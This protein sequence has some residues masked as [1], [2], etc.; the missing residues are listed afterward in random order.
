MRVRKE[1]ATLPLLKAYYKADPAQF[2]TDWG[3][4]VD[5]R[6]VERGLPALIPFILTPR[7]RQWVAYIIDCWKRQKPGLTEKSRDS[8]VSWLAVSLAC[9]LCLFYD[10]MAVGFGSRKEEYVDKLGAPKALFPKA[11]IFMQN[12]P[13]EFRCGWELER[14]APHMRINFPETESNISGEA[15][16]NIGRGD[17]TSIYF[18]DESAFIE[19]P[20][21]IE[22]SLSQTTNC[23]QDISNPNGRANPFA[24]KRFSGR[25]EVF[26][27]HWSEDPRKSVEWYT[28]Q[29]DE[30]D[31]VTVAQEINIDYAASVEGVLIPAEWIYSAIDAHLR[32]AI[33][34]TGERAGA[35]DVADEGKDKNAFIGSHGILVEV[36]EEWSGKGGD[37]FGTVER[38]FT[39][40]DVNGYAKFRYDADGLGSGVRGDARVL[41]ERR[42]HKLQVDAYRGSGAVV[43]PLKEDVRGRTNEDFFDNF[44]AQSWWALRTRFQ[45]THRAVTQGHQ[46]PASE[47]VSISSAAQ[48]YRKLIV[49]LSQPTYGQNKV[50]KIVIDKAPDGARSPNLADAMVIRFAAPIRAPMR[51]SRAVL[52]AA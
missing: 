13:V 35:L 1:P 6:N 18:V 14:D 29:T 17:R 45:M 50:G 34:P 44:K 31:P 15:G 11:R 38:A 20:E 47:L 46:Y 52:Q 3:V 40:C 48:N 41:N 16:D 26:T 39:L 8:G 30:L 24:E 21:L 7:Q 27:F 19:H 51:I 28:K 33:K 12:L 23:R 2:I 10:G 36:I 43:N 22:H 4:T 32:L 5:P 9:T 25:I 42:K 37:I 49:E